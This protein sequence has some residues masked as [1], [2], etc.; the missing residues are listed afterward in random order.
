MFTKIIAGAALVLTL[1]LGGGAWALANKKADDCCYPGSPCCY[2]GSPCCDDCCPTGGCCPDGACCAAPAAKQDVQP[3][4]CPLT[5]EELPC[6][7]C[8]P[9][10][11]AQK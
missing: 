1:G 7:N 10:G 9:L 4:I 5:G 3:V 6:P 11:K 8:C 2:A